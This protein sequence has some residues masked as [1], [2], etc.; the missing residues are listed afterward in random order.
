MMM[1]LLLLLII[2]ITTTIIA[3]AHSLEAYSHEKPSKDTSQQTTGPSFK[4]AQGSSGEWATGKDS[5]QST[6]ATN[7]YS[8]LSQPRRI[9]SGRTPDLPRSHFM[10]LVYASC[11]VICWSCHATP[12]HAMSCHVPRSIGNLQELSTQR[13]LEGV[14]FLGPEGISHKFRLRDS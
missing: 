10:H 4:I 11:Y 2:I 12:R 13:F 14:G 9:V 1:I 8:W 7:R 6:W 3:D 5:E